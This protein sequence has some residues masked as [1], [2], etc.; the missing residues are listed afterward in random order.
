M[1]NQAGAEV[2]A[3]VAI[4]EANAENCKAKLRERRMLGILPYKVRKQRVGKGVYAID[5]GDKASR[6]Q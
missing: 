4:N 5:R 6:D 1:G 3:W 2:V